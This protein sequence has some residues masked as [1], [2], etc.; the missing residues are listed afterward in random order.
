[1]RLPMRWIRGYSVVVLGG[2]ALILL[3][4]VA[5]SFVF[6]S[7]MQ[8]DATLALRSARVDRLVLEFTFDLV[9]AETAQRGYIITHVEDYLEPYNSALTQFTDDAQELRKWAAD[10]DGGTAIPQLAI[11]ELIAAGQRK[12]DIVQTNLANIKAGRMQ[13]EQ[14]FETSQRG[15]EAMD[16]VRRRADSIRELTARVRAGYAAEMRSSAST[17]IMLISLGAAMIIILVGGAALVIRR[18]VEALDDTRRDLVEINE[19]L[20]ARVR[21]RTEMVMRSNEELQRYAYIVSHDLRAPLVNIMGFTSELETD[22][23]LL[24]AH[25]YKL[26]GD[27]E[28]PAVKEV[29]LAAEE[30]IPEA[31]TFIRSS[32]T[33]MDG[34]INEILKLSRAGRRLLEPT[35]I[36]MTGLVSGCIDA[37]R[38]HFAVA[39]TDVKIEGDLPS[40]ISDR[41]ALEQIFTNLLDNAAKYLVADRPGVIRIRGNLDRHSARYEVEDNGRGIAEADRERVFELFRRAGQQDRPGDG[42]GLAHT[43]MLARRLGGDVTI[44][45]D[46]QSGTTFIVTVARDLALRMGK[47]GHE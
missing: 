17:L 42:I 36:D 16:E 45:S 1:M 26:G 22:L 20:E 38:Q 21:E 41:L 30:S 11:D 24:T 31:L 35:R 44:K 47:A 43:R 18:H 29:F 14:L 8:Q 2:G 39:G 9:N 19:D 3:T 33:R 6:S 5:A 28:D 15:K 40:V 27:R 13:P 7:R 23:A 10:L 37:I 12:L 34:L 46:G 25:I 32:M 4:I